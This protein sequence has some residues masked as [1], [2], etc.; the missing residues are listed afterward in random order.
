MPLK[1]A[2]TAPR[3]GIP[4]TPLCQ[5]LMSLTLSPQPHSFSLERFLKDSSCHTSLGVC[6]GSVAAP[7]RSK[8]E[9]ATSY[10]QAHLLYEVCPDSAGGGKLGQAS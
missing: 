2:G 8:P 9:V 5:G 4:P 3:Q 7:R 10:S 1:F 6:T